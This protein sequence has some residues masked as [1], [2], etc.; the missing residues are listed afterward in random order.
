VG[1]IK[2]IKEKTK[3]IMASAPKDLVVYNQ[4]GSENGTLVG[5][6]V[7]VCMH[8]CIYTCMHVYLRM[9]P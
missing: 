4:S 2:K 7:Y 9:E 8:V 5:M 1:S 6:I 3:K